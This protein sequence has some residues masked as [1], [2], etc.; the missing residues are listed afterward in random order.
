MNT[1][2]QSE[3]AI[4]QIMPID[5]LD[6]IYQPLNYDIGIIDEHTENV[7]DQ[8]MPMDADADADADADVLN[9][10]DLTLDDDT[11][12]VDEHTQTIPN[13]NLKVNCWHNALNGDIRP[14]DVC[15]NS[16]TKYWFQCDICNH[17]FRIQI[18]DIVENNKWC[19]YC[20]GRKLCGEEDCD[21]C[22]IQSFA[23]YN[24]ITGIH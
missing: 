3:Q 16:N 10:I 5:V 8:I 1:D 13:M 12:L 4:D 2:T 7:I 17:D 23:S 21:H 22:I 24:G 6:V 19:P 11:D 9:I 20:D 14:I 18:N 15:R